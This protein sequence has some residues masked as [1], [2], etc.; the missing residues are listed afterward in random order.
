MKLIKQKIS[1]TFNRRLLADAQIMC[2]LE[3]YKIVYPNMSIT[4]LIRTWLL[5]VVLADPKLRATQGTALELM[6]EARAPKKTPL[7]K[8]VKQEVVSPVVAVP[9]TPVPVITPAPVVVATEPIPIVVQSEVASAPSPAPVV[10]S[11]PSLTTKTEVS[12]EEKYRPLSNA[13]MDDLR[14]F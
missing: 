1:I 12:R 13:P 7:Q 4:D 9:V 14:D 5:K 10:L 6:T 11:A 3:H 2:A 8:R